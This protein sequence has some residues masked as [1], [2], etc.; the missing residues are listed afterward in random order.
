MAGMTIE[1]RLVPLGGIR[2]LEVRRTL[3][4]KGLPTIGP[5]CFLDH[6]GP[7]FQAMDVLPH[8]HIGLQT[9]TWLLSG[10]IEHRD[11]LGSNVRVKPGQLN[12]MTAGRGVAHSE[13][14][15][16]IDESMHGV[17][18]WVA[19][20]ESERGGKADFE[21]FTELPIVD[22]DGWAATVFVG[23]F[24]GA[25]SPAT[26][27]SPIVAAQIQLGSGLHE[28]DLDPAFEYG[29]LAVD[30]SVVI[31][32]EQLES[33][34]LRFLAAGESKLTIEVPFSTTVILLG[35][36]PWEEPLIMWWN[37]VARTHDEIHQAREDWE[38]GHERFGS[39]DGHDGKVI[40][41]PPL[42]PVRLKP[43]VRRLP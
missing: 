23:E 8:P 29:L 37:F 24:Y 42:P 7:T 38:S 20:P 6:F 39:V 41:A 30:M 31:D 28:I 17:Q 16:D 14:S 13:F 22:G 35:G 26:T 25:R 33:K 2:A 5:W 15:C 12:I 40:P 27:F 4:T 21:H 3:P 1:P 32:G 11:N 9:V 10:E 34:S 43:R 36:E 18:F 19:L